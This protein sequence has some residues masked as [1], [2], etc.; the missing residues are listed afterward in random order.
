MTS[1]DKLRRELTNMATGANTSCREFSALL[2][3]L[4]FE[5]VPCGS[6]GHMIAK[7]PAVALLEYP[8]FNCGHDRGT[9]VKRVYVKKLARFVDEHADALKEYLK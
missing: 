3:D 1:F 8:D 9:M 5:L 2:V 7:H 6:A 4:R